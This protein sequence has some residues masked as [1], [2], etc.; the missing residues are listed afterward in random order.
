MTWLDLNPL[1]DFQRIDKVFNPIQ[2]GRNP[3]FVVIIHARKV[4]LSGRVALHIGKGNVLTGPAEVLDFFNG[5]ELSVGG[6]TMFALSSRNRKGESNIRLSVEELPNQFSLRESVSKVVTEYGIANLKGLTLRERA[7]ALIDI[8]HPDDRSEL[9]EQAKS[10]N[11]LYRD[12][13]FLTESAHLYPANIATEHT[14]KSG[15]KVRFRAI[16]PSDEE[17]MRRLFYRFSDES[18]YY[19]YFSAIKTMPH[20]KMQEYV[21]VDW[22]QVMS[23]VGLVGASGQEKIIAEARYIKGQRLPYAEVVFVVDEQYQGLGIATYLYKM[24]VRLA[25]ERGVKGF[26]ADVLFS[27]IG[28]MKVF[29]KGGLPVKASLEY[30]EYHLTIP[31][32]AKSFS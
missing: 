30:G 26:T 2:I 16:K 11:I 22:S 17:A 19:R 14:F 27:N 24:L 9:V 3:R 1:V 5:A 7:Q 6:H 8:A 12:Q 25:R 23:I 13:I 10:E 28:M 21:N 29:K 20:A 31:F 32:E 18:V 4:D 15:I